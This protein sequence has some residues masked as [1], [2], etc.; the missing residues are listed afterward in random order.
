MV[1]FNDLLKKLKIIERIDPATIFIRILL[2]RNQFIH[3]QQQSKRNLTQP[4]IWFK[5]E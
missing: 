1:L 3:L 2:P 5:F 4:L